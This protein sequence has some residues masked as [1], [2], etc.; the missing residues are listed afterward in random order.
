ME[1]RYK[2]F[3]GGDW[4]PYE[5]ETKECFKKLVDEQEV[6]GLEGDLS[7]IWPG[8]DNWPDYLIAHSKS[9]F[10]QLEQ[11][12]C[13]YSP[14]KAEDIYNVWKRAEEAGDLNEWYKTVEADETSKAMCYY[15][16][17]VYSL[18]DPK[19]ITVDFRLYFTLG[20]EAKAFN[21]DDEFSLTP[22]EE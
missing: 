22:Y 17:K 4:N 15:M 12:I 8:L 16:E 13:H 19:D 1:L 14:G 21:G 3:R 10:W 20:M 5:K 2:F 18:F 9:V 11:N 6:K 7:K